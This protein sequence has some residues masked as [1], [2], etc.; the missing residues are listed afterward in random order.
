MKNLF[1]LLAFS[2]FCLGTHATTWTVNNLPG[3]SA[4]FS[5]LSAAIAASVQGDSIY[6]QPSGISYGTITIDKQLFILGAGHHPGFNNGVAAITGAITINGTASGTF[7]KGIYILGNIVGGSSI[8]NVV[9][10]GC[11]IE[12][13]YNF[14][15]T[16]SGSTGWIVEGNVLIVTSSSQNFY[17]GG[18]A[19]AW[20]IRNNYI[21]TN[22]INVSTAIHPSAVFEHN[23]V[24]STGT[25][26]CQFFASA[27]TGANL[28][29][30][31]FITQSNAQSTYQTN[32][33]N[34]NW[35]NNISYNPN[36]AMADLPGSNFN[37]TDPNFINAASFSWDYAWDFG[38][39]NSSV[40]YQAATD[41]GDI[42]LTGGSHTFNKFGYNNSLPRIE[43]VILNDSSVPSGGTLT[44]QLQA[45]GAGN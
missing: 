17:V 32:C 38:L 40:G 3:S 16:G 34:C 27:T 30:N 12:G 35:V 33:T 15:A 44:I 8:T 39:L 13:A 22:Q 1:A 42:G 4:D 14:N 18:N 29:D 11:R 37:N 21:Q 20:T 7:I 9:I 41:Q 36:S 24:V 10:S 6:V 43:S 5:S 45:V 26:A 23:L 25:A 28:R 31:I 19:I 2:L